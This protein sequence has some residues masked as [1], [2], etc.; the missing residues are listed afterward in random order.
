MGYAHMNN[1]FAWLVGYILSGYLLNAFCP[2]P[3]T[4]DP[5]T[6]LTYEAALRGQGPMPAAYAHA[7]YLWYVFAAVG[8]VAFVMLLVFQYTSG[9]DSEAGEEQAAAGPG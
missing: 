8:A 4:L 2:D 7:H 1:F 5:A 6:R 3:A 9:S